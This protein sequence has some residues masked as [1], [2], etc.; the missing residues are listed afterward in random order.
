[1]LCVETPAI[2]TSTATDLTLMWISTKGGVTPEVCITEGA[3]SAAREMGAKHSLG[4]WIN[5]SDEIVEE[6][7]M[8]KR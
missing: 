3:L 8:A 7:V 5:D 6:A 1:M 4:W 2:W